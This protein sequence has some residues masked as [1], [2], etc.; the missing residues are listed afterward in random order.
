MAFANQMVVVTGA[1]SGIGWALAKELP[2]QGARVGLV[3]RRAD[4]LAELAGEIR[5]AGG[6]TGKVDATATRRPACHFRGCGRPWQARFAG[7]E[8]AY[9]Y[10]PAL[11]N[12]GRP[13]NNRKVATSAAILLP[14][15]GL[16]PCCLPAF[17]I[18]GRL[19]WLVR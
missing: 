19:C 4:K 15:R 13:C 18:V 9:L 6:T 1:S 12:R 3:A 5:G 7:P 16:S 10:G 8:R 11:G 17:V 2:R 14:F